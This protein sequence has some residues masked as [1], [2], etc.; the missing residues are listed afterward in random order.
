MSRSSTKTGQILE[1][2]NKKNHYE[3]VL[4]PRETMKINYDIPTLTTLHFNNRFH[5]E[6]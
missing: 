5:N 4:K 1:F 2:Y 6:S 3:H